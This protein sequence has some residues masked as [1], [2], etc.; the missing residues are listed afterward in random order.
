MPRAKRPASTADLPPGI[1]LTAQ[2]TYR[3]RWRD[4]NGRAKGKTFKRL[5][6]AKRHLEAMRTDL[7][8]GVYFD[9]SRA[10]LTVARFADEWLASARN[11]GAG[12]RD[13]YRRDLDRYI[14]PV[15]GDARLGQ[16]DVTRIDEF[17]NDELERGLAPSSVHRH[18][19]TI[20]R[21]CEVAV[22]SGRLRE[23]PCDTVTPPKVRRGE[24]RFLDIDQVAALADAISPRYRAWVLLAAYGGPRWS[25]SIGL[26]R[27]NVHGARVRIVEQY[28][29]RSDGEWH[30]DE[31][32]TA[33][34]RRTIT[35][36]AVAADALADHLERWA[37]PGDDGLVFVNQHGNPV[38]IHNFTGMVF[39]PAL[40]RAGLDDRIR[41]HDLRHTAVALAIRV[42]AHPKAIQARMGHASITVT[43]DRY[44]HVFPEMDGEIA[45]GLDGLVDQRAR[46]RAAVWA[47][48]WALLAAGGGQ[49][50]RAV[51]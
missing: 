35:L 46:A 18:Y 3:A 12:G 14:L 38:G 2:G 13:T 33:A 24:M 39:K 17:I 36:P 42:G 32:K 1:V 26:R 41:I 44:G 28:V 16:L 11:L 6:D 19:R 48:R 34:G 8:R 22:R 47:V 4:A 9:P 31:P 23:N 21:M 49:G 15:L 45:A 29:R 5:I 30:R 51:A 10:R 20:R 7:H 27:G 43:L 37:Q 50:L 40:R 25:E